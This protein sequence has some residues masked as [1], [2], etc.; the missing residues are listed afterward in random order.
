MARRKLLTGTPGISTGAWKLRK[1]PACER[2]SVDRSVIS[3]P[4][5]V[6]LPPVTVYSGSPITTWP[7]VDLPAPFGPISTW[8]SPA[9]TV[10]STS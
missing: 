8:V 3:C 10:R 1:R 6:I 9:P 4:L 5:N 7:S 2:L